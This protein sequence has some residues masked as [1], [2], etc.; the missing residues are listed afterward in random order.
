MVAVVSLWLAFLPEL[1]LPTY[2]LVVIE[3]QCL[4]YLITNCKSSFLPENNEKSGTLTKN[5]VS[6]SKRS[7]QVIWVPL[8]WGH[9]YGMFFFCDK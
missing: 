5:E 3:F 6:T 8:Y 9:E 7:V 1:K 2:F 4:F